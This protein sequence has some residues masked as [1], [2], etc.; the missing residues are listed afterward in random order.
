M[1][2]DSYIQLKLFAGLQK[3]Q[4]PDPENHPIEAGITV[5]AVLAQLD[6]P[7]NQIKLIFIDGV[8]AK[9]NTI[10]RGGERVGIFPPV[11]GG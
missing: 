6:V 2:K 11:G 5:G 1:S 3:Y 4:P 7:K 10:L 9:L 8:K